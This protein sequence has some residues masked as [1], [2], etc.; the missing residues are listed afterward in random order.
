MRQK[1]KEKLVKLI[2]RHIENLESVISRVGSK[3][4]SGNWQKEVD[5]YLK[6]KEKLSPDNIVENEEAFDDFLKGTV[7][8]MLAGFALYHIITNFI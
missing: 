4:S 7:V 5:E 3:S 2:D 1:E 8:G 6:I